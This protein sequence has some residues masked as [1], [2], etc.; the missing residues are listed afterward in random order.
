MYCSDTC[1][2][3]VCMYTLSCTSY[4]YTRGR[5]LH[6]ACFPPEIQFHGLVSQWDKRQVPETFVRGTGTAFIIIITICVVDFAR[7]G[8]VAVGP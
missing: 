8:Q 2:N 5:W 6:V 3:E 1:D 4:V 7:G